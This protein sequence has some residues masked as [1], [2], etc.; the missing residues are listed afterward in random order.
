MS[1]SIVLPGSKLATEEEYAPGKNAFEQDGNIYSD[2]V[3]KPSYDSKQK[4]ASVTKT[5]PLHILER[6]CIV[7]GTVTLVKDN[8]VNV[9]LLYAENADGR[10]VIPSSHAKLPVRNVSR[11]FIKDLKQSFR[12]GDLIRAKIASASKLGI[13]L[14]TNEP[15]LG[16]VKGYCANCRTALHR[17]GN[18]L[19]C[20]ACGVAENRKIARDYLV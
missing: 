20:T 15:E 18:V 9:E 14:R 4:L 8:F 10:V 13:D 5:K 6:N 16:I 2:S 7:Y 3:G 12:I 17:F 11:E 1:E 19:K